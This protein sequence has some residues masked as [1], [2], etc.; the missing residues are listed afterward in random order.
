MSLSRKL[1]EHG[2]A[3]H[4]VDPCADQT[5]TAIA[6]AVINP[7]SG[8]KY[9]IQWNFNALYNCARTHYAAMENDYH[10]SLLREME[11][12]KLHKSEEALQQWDQRKTTRDYGNYVDTSCSGEP[13]MANLNLPFGA[14]RIRHVLHV[15]APKLIH[16]FRQHAGEAGLLKEEMFH[17]PDLVVH[18]TYCNW[19]NIRYARVIFCEGAAASKNPWFSH[20]P[21]I[22]SKGECLIIGIKGVDFPCIIHK[23]IILI[24][25]GDEKYWAGASNDWDDLDENPTEAGRQMIENGLRNMLRTP[26]TVLHHMAAIRP[27]MRDRTPV[28]GSHPVCKNIF[29]M[30][31]MGTKGASLAPFYAGVLLDHIMQGTALPKEVDI[32]RFEPRKG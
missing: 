22:P 24:P 11:M 21:Y 23:G 2:I 15:D 6:G 25:L 26:W 18:D 7:I 28:M 31:G 10:I 16:A 19:K 17:Y 5:A 29:L 20:L 3:H 30:N 32:R 13:W 4:I 1:Q 27:A 9:N 8:R 12:Y 14:I